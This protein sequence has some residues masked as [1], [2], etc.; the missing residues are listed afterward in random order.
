VVRDGA[1]RF[2]SVVNRGITATN[3]RATSSAVVRTGMSR[4]AARCVQYLRCECPPNTLRLHML[5]VYRAPNGARAPFARPARSGRRRGRDPPGTSRKRLALPRIRPEIGVIRATWSNGGRAWRARLGVTSDG[6]A[7]ACVRV[8][9]GREGQ[10]VGSCS[11]GCGADRPARGGPDHPRPSPAGMTSAAA[12]PAS[13]PVTVDR[14]PPA[15]VIVAHE[16][17]LLRLAQPA[18]SPVGT[19]RE[20]PRPAE[21][22]EVVD[23]QSS[24]A[25]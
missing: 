1:R 8:T 2:R 15:P 19:P 4:S 23:G 24:I 10:H 6:A 25:G 7:P 12:S 14:P 9:G 16:Q 17:L 20:Q 3:R 21:R 22:G 5:P 18:A 11:D 13:T